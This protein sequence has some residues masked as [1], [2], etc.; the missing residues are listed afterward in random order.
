[1]NYEDL[2]GEDIWRLL[3]EK[4]TPERKQRIE[5]VASARTN[6][7]RLVIQDI[8]HPHNVSA[9]L[10][11]AE[12]FGINQVDVVKIREKF[13]PSTVSRGTAKWL[14]LKTWNEID[15][16]AAHL[17]KEGYTLVCARPTQDST[18]VWT[19]PV[20]QKLALVFGNE[21]SGPDP[22][23]DKHLDKSFTIP[24]VGMVESLNVS[25]A[26]AVSLN[27]LTTRSLEHLGPSGYYLKENERI[28]LLGK[29]IQA[30][31][32]NPEYELRALCQ[33]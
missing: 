27:I 26:A 24:M 22:R 14:T 31:S 11:S 19:L 6:H 4:L 15:A 9:C 21:H 28:N 2:T 20:D 3:S 33:K 30:H 25:V 13:S 7:I 12:A 32:T 10:R 5:Q 16:C 1:M 8:H 17:K 23:W 18:S 29:F